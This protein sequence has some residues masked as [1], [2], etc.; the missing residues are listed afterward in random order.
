MHTVPNPNHN[1]NPISGKRALPESSGAGNN[2]KV[3][4]HKMPVHSAGRKFCY[5]PLHFSLV[6]LQVRGHSKKQDGNGREARVSLQ[7]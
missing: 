6:P 1:H 5:V 7:V 2:L 3:E 4:G